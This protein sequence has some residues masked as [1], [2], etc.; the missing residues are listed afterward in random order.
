MIQPDASACESVAQNQLPELLIQ[1]L[2]E[3][4]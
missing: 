2:F 3:H 4:L 1:F